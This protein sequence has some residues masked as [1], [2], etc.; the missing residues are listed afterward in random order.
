MNLEEN[1]DWEKIRF[2]LRKVFSVSPFHICF[3][4]SR[5]RGDFKEKSDYNFYLIASAEDQIR[6]NFIQEITKAIESAGK[7]PVNLIA[8]DRESF[9]Q[10][11]EIF[12]PTA[13]HLLEFGRI[14]YGE[15]EFLPVINEWKSVRKGPIDQS[16]ILKYLENRTRFYKTLKPRQS[17]DDIS[18]IEKILALT[19]QTWII[20][21]T[22]D[23]TVTE[24]AFMDI[25]ERLIKMVRSLYAGQIPKDIL[26]LA[27]IYEE[28]HELKRNMRSLSG[29]EK[30]DLD[31]IKESIL[32]IKDISLEIGNFA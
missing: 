5:E 15:R 31:K 27:T 28:I 7:K 4:G 9:I 24:L 3:Y 2:H 29:T 6:S 12:E 16:Q 23:L 14:I 32:Q 11:M 26:L 20:G 22:D 10:R 19:I 25:P 30:S 21:C 13:V 8:G 18:R 17:K 1:I